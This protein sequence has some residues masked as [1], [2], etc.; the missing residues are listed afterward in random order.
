MIITDV[1][2]QYA[3][4]EAF[5]IFEITKLQGLRISLTQQLGKQPNDVKMADLFALEERVIDIPPFGK[6]WSISDW[7]LGDIDSK[8]SD[9]VVALSYWDIENDGAIKF[10]K[11]NFNVYPL[12]F[13]GKRILNDRYNLEASESDFLLLKRANPAIRVSIYVYGRPFGVRIAVSVTLQIQ[14]MATA[15]AEKI[16]L[17]SEVV[18][19][20]FFLNMKGFSFQ[21]AQHY[22]YEPI[23]PRIVILGYLGK[24]D[25]LETLNKDI[26]NRLEHNLAM[27]SSEVGPLSNLIINDSATLLAV[28]TDLTYLIEDYSHSDYTDMTFFRLIALGSSQDLLSLPDYFEFR[29]KVPILFGAPNTIAPHLKEVATVNLLFQWTENVKL[30]NAKQT[31]DKTLA[32]TEMYNPYGNSAIRNIKNS[33]AEIYTN[34]TRLDQEISN[35]MDDIDFLSKI[36]PGL[37]PITLEQQLAPQIIV[38]KERNQIRNLYRS[39]V[40]GRHLAF[41]KLAEMVH[42]ERSERTQAFAKELKERLWRYLRLMNAQSQIETLKQSN[43]LV[44]YTIGLLF[45]T[46]I[47]V[48]VLILVTLGV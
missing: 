26:R 15:Q 5:D 12:N 25:E 17:F 2:P 41:S 8:S 28:G 23:V 7:K 35:I 45:L 9:S 37:A 4:V 36:A 22:P 27:D 20:A 43:R 32:R 33:T 3:W 19:E 14:E 30:K 29:G 10:L 34:L 47:S 44:K 31:L 40:L 24:K 11:E 39:S 13:E 21:M 38:S 6:V 48:I 1:K 42:E 18:L 46:A 16:E